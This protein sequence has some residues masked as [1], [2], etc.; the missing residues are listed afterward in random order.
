MVQY[1]KAVNLDK[2]EVCLSVV[3]TRWC[4]RGGA[5]LW[6]WAASPYGIVFTLLLRK[7]STRPNEIGCAWHGCVTSRICRRTSRRPLR[8]LF[9]AVVDAEHGQ[10]MHAR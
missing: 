10:D 2:R 9:S 5:K 1:F 8:V 7:S 4:L 3:P 6:E